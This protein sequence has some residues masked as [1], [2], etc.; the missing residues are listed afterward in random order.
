MDFKIF[1]KIKM[2]TH[3]SS[4]KE[5]LLEEIK[6]KRIYLSSDDI[7][8][9]DVDKEHTMNYKGEILHFMIKKNVY[10]CKDSKKIQERRT[11]LKSEPDLESEYPSSETV[12]V[13]RRDVII[14]QDF[15]NRYENYCGCKIC[16]FIPSTL[17]EY[18]GFYFHLYCLHCFGCIHGSLDPED[19]IMDISST[20][21]F[22]MIDRKVE[23]N[24]NHSI[25]C[26]QNRIKSNIN[27][28]LSILFISI[29]LYYILR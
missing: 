27:I 4:T 23:G 21:I 25:R 9:L 11:Y 7:I 8:G 1:F 17:P 20:K 28:C 15:V 18:I 12:I 29:F 5:E 19:R 14:N 6:D 24:N 10:I 3:T 13:Y 2:I 22:D 16:N 26:E